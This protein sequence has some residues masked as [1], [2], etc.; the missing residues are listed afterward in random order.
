MKKVFI[1]GG[2][3]AGWLAALMLNKSFPNLQVEL[4]ESAEIG[5]LGAGE[6]TLHNFKTEL[7]SLNIDIFD[8]MKNTNATFKLGTRYDEWNGDK[9]F[10]LYH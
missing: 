4:I 9:D 8:F 6:S 3:T 10:P 5:I 7:Q 1:V 2:G